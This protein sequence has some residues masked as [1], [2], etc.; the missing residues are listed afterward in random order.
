MGSNVPR[1]NAG[2]ATSAPNTEELK[3]HWTRQG[4]ADFRPWSIYISKWAASHGWNPAN[5]PRL[6]HSFYPLPHSIFQEFDSTW[7]PWERKWA[8]RSICFCCCESISN[9]IN[10]CRPRA[11]W[12]KEKV[13]LENRDWLDIFLFLASKSHFSITVHNRQKYDRP[14]H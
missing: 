3:E 1:I 7:V 8:Q 14:Y 13:K 4:L 12:Q 5:H 9:L 2:H 10:H 6:Q 11:R